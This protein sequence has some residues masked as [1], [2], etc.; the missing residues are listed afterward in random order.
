MALL[1]TLKNIGIGAGAGLMEAAGSPY[2]LERLEERRQRQQAFSDEERKQGVDLYNQAITGIQSKLGATDPKSPEYG[3]LQ[4]TLKKAIRGRTMM[5][6]PALSRAGQTQLG[7]L[8]AA[9]APV[10]KDEFAGLTPEENKRR[11]RIKAGLEP[12]AVPEKTE[13]ENWVPTNVKLKD[14]TEVTW[15][16]NTKSGKWTD[17]AGNPISPEMMS[18]ATVASKPTAGSGSKFNEIRESY[19][20][21][22]GI[23]VDQLTPEDY[24]YINQKIAHDSRVA[25]SSTSIRFEKNEKNQYVP[26]QYTNTRGIGPQPVDPRAQKSIPKTPGEA[27]KKIAPPIGGPQV[28]I[29]KPLFG[30]PSKD[31][32]DTKSAYEAAIDRTS[33]MDQNLANALQGDQQAMLSLVANHIGMTLGAQRGARITRAVWDEAVE[34]TPWLQRVAA[35]FDERGFL[36]GVTLAPDQMRQMVRLAHEKVQTLKDHMDRLEKER[37]AASTTDQTTSDDEAIIKALS[38]VKQ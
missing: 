2:A 6:H 35:K 13:A 37:G 15:Q 12:H 4:E 22:W 10:E 8:L 31:Y 33:T 9:G 20:R 25:G 30:A 23:S 14:G 16:R 1:D 7:P 38:G 36:S 17:L 19:A 26:I 5:F 34:S 18:G 28:K 11:I 24:S 32:T 21:K 27:K 3:Q 29:G